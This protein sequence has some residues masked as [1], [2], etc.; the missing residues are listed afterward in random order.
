MVNITEVNIISIDK[1]D[2]PWAIE[3]EILFEGDLSTD[4]SVN[5]TAD[6]DELEDLEIEINPGSYDKSLLKE[7]IVKAALDYE[8]E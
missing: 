5:Y 2:D 7:M 8:E 3:G 6:Y 4:F 1:S